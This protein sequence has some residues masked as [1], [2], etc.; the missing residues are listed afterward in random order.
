[1]YNDDNLKPTKC[2]TVQ[3][4]KIQ[5]KGQRAAVC[6]DWIY[7]HKVSF[8]QTTEHLILVESFHRISAS[9]ASN[10]RIYFVLLLVT[11]ICSSIGEQLQTTT[12]E[13][14]L[15][16]FFFYRNLKS[17][18]AMWIFVDDSKTIFFGCQMLEQEF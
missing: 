8:A 13:H 7:L 15:C 6:L 14:F 5:L 10:F 4:T 3:T 1:M 2:K 18:T 16:L 11:E 9:L 12:V 17:V